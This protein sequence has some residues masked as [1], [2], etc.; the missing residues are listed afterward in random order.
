MRYLSV[1][2][3]IEAASAAWEPL[4]WECVGVSE[5]D[6]F[7]SAA[8]AH[9][10]PEVCNFGDFTTIQKQDI[11]G[12]VD[13][14]VGG[15]PCQSFSV[16]GLRR[17]MDDERGN[18]ALQFV[19]LAF[20]LGVR[21]VVWENVP[22]VFSS[23]GGRD[24]AS[25]LSGLTGRNIPVPKNGWRNS[26]IIEPAEG[27]FGIAWRVLDAQYVRVE[28]HPRAV[29]QR[30]RRV[31]V[32]GCLGSWQRAA[33]VL[34]ERESMRRNTPPRRE[35]G[36]G[37][38]ADVAP[39]IGASGR[40]FSRTGETRGQ[41]PV[42]SGTVSSKWAK[43][44]GGPAGD[45]C[46]NL[47]TAR[48][49]GKGFWTDDGTG[50]LRAQ[51]GGMPENLVAHALRA[52][53]FDASEDGTGRGTPLTVA[54]DCKASGRSGFGVGDVASTMRSMGHA[55]SHQNGGGHQAVAYPIDTMNGL[56]RPDCHS[57]GVGNADDP[58]Y[59]LSKA[60]GHA[61]AIP[62]QCVRRLT[63]RECERLQGFPDDYTLVPYRG[64][65]ASDGPRYK[66]LGNS[67]A[68]NCMFYIGQR[69]QMVDKLTERA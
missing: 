36:K 30:R 52:D 47:V 31:F 37:T 16:A 53:G 42:V 55:G 10:H 39:S 3:G 62:T 25:F 61:V 26:G 44:T 13:L 67:M 23:A 32:V 5:I 15:T 50:S 45:E 18:L 4:G 59:T 29:P 68:V 40:G 21:I 54:F 27:F 14:L 28:S 65:P 34:F 69:I 41:D 48:E 24:F 49:T 35:A 60:H 2:S 8:L 17:G 1:C 33:A 6:A 46:Q 64:K 7:P 57:V 51:P 19:E 22:G 56:S 43:G 20:R 66:A 12:P 11:D 38:A 63:P 9:H 58:S